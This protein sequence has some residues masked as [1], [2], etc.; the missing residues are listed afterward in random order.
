MGQPLNKARHGRWQSKPWT[1]QGLCEEEQSPDTGGVIAQVVLMFLSSSADNDVALRPTISRVL[2]QR[3]KRYPGAARIDLSSSSLKVCGLRYN[4]SATSMSRVVGGVNTFGLGEWPWQASLQRNNAHR[5]GATL[6]SSTWLVSAAH[7]FKDAGNPQKW[8]VSFGPYLKPPLSVRIVKSITVHEKYSYPS[9]EY[10]IAVVK[11]AKRVDFTRSVH[12]V[13][14]PDAT[15]VFP[16]NIDAVVTG[17]GA[18]SNDGETPNVLQQ[19]TVELIDSDTCNRKEVYNGVIT[20]GML[21]AGYLEGGVDSCQGDSGGP[22]V[23]PDSRGM[24]YLVGI[25]SWGDECAK[26]NKPGVYTRVTYYRDWI[27]AHTGL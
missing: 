6:I 23:T 20:P 11:L 25:V 24:W 21:C 18:L 10:D 17:W 16:Y 1:P 4:K 3:L 2:R 22:L 9:H 5:C 14:L 27:A 19:A 8:T 15:E 7:C 13:C 12:R 26:P